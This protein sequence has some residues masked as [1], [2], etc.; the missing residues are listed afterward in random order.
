M[1]EKCAIKII[2]CNYWEREDVAKFLIDITSN[3]FGFSHWR[4]YFEK[5]MPQKYKEGKNKFW[6]V[7][8]AE[9]QIIGTCGAL[10]VDEK[11]I[12]MNCFYVDIKYRNCGIGNKLY[13][14]FLE[15]VKKENYKTIILCTFKEFDIAIKFYE[16]NG[17]K[18]YETTED[19]FWYK[20]EL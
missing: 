12:K 20:K 18:L 15:F 6:I 9:N 13:D 4:E 10:Q 8:N 1:L 19:E 5:K 16:K 7:L 2:E 3:E 17:F 11:T 14:L